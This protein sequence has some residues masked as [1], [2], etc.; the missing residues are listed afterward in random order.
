MSHRPLVLVS[1]LTF[2][3]YLLWHWSLNGNHDVLALVS[4]LT[5][6]PLGVAFVWLLVLTAM[7]LL[8]RPSRAAARRVHAPRRAAPSRQAP[9]AGAAIAGGEPENTPAAA[10]ASRRAARKIAA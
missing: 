7:R 10:S 4:G 3:D 2:G 6:P 8:V 1:G 5:L 9:N